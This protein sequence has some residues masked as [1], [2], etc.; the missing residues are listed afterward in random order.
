MLFPIIVLLFFLLIQF[1]SNNV[2]FSKEKYFPYFV[3]LFSFILIETLRIYCQSYFPDIPN[4]QQIF[5]ET[6]SLLYLHKQ[7]Y[8]TEYFDSVLEIGFSLLI[9]F[10]KI[11]SNN[12]SIF[13]FFVSIVELITFYFFCSK[14]RINIANAI[15]VYIAFTFITFQIGMLRQAL[16]FC[17]FLVSLV[18][19]HRKVLFFSLVLIGMTLHTS[20][21]FCLLLF[22]VDK[23]VNRKLYYILFFISIL[24]Y[25]FKVDL[26]GLYLPF[27]QLGDSIQ[28]ARVGYYLNVERPNSYLGVGFWE[29]LISF[30]LLNIIYSKLIEKNKITRNNNIIYNL[31]MVVILVQMIF[32]SS[33]TITSRLRYYIVFFPALFM[34]EYIFNEIF[35]DF[36]WVYQF[37]FAAYLIMY[38]I[39]L[40]TYL[41]E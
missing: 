8:G 6:P 16:A 19:I 23:F 5:E 10:F 27:V 15:P 41:I 13:L 40:A 18:Y 14:Y 12:F 9:S 39:S 24:I 1:I 30:F 26:I 21:L 4:Y 33:P 2:D 35:D 17:F 11:F 36:K 31:A 3:I 22:W 7:K 32:F 29:R 28:T 37:L 38:L 34:S 25:L 20:I